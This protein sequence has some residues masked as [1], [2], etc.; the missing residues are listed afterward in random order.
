MPATCGAR[1]RGALVAARQAEA[2]HA[3]VNVCWTIERPA[4]SG[5]QWSASHALSS[6]ARVDASA[7]GHHVEVVPAFEY[8]ASQPFAVVAP[9]AI[10]EAARA[11]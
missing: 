8:S 6:L 11:G 10:T 4:R 7:R 9:T 2:R 5:R 3:A 1:H